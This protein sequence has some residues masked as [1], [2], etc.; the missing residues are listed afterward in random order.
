[1]SIYGGLAAGAT[2]LGG[3]GGG[4]GWRSSFSCMAANNCESK[5][6]AYAIG[7]ERVVLEGERDAESRTLNFG[8]IHVPSFGPGGGVVHS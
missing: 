7:R 6:A 2:E 4:G 1:M 3:H 5:S 8:H